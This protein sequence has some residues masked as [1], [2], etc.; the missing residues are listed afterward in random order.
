MPLEPFYAGVP[1]ERPIAYPSYFKAFVR[2]ASHEDVVRRVERF[3]HMTAPAIVAVSLVK[4]WASMIYLDNEHA[5]S[6]QSLELGLTAAHGSV[7]GGWYRAHGEAIDSKT[8]VASAA[9]RVMGFALR[10]LMRARE[11]DARRKWTPPPAEGGVVVPV[12]VQRA[13]STP[14]PT[15]VEQKDFDPDQTK[16]PMHNPLPV[17]PF[18][19]TT[20]PERLR[21]MAAASPP[22][23]SEDA[24]ETAML[25]LP[26]GFVRRAV[27][28]DPPLLP[29][30]EY[31]VLRA[32]LSL[33]GED[34]VRTLA[35]FGLS[36]EEKHRLQQTYF[37]RFRADPRLQTTFEELL[38][39]EMRKI[40]RSTGSRS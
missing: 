34:D 9:N 5:R 14:A 22:L 11:A 1:T 12:V 40:N 28:I 39:E 2:M 35:Q 25:P 7:G 33:Y 16:A 38:R 37:E 30:R 24:G 13:L 23:S 17:L 10:R 18:S 21:E 32:A 26:E 15:E 29:L 36:K 4:D 8:P 6:A 19:G 3:L 31:A 27:A 20:S